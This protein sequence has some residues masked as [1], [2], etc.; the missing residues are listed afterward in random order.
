MPLR[1]S[2]EPAGHAAQL[3]HARPQELAVERR[4][5]DDH[6]SAGRG[7]VLGIGALMVARGMGIGYEQR[8][9]AGR[10]E[11]PDGAAGAAHAEIGGG[12]DVQKRSVVSSTR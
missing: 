1:M 11:L 10:C 9:Q 5:V 6:R 8:G 4:V 3:G 2:G 7:E 12:Q